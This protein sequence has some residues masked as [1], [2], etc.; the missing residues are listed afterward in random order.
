MKPIV[1]LFLVVAALQAAAPKTNLIILDET[2]VK[3]L[4]IALTEAEETVFEK[5]IFA[6]GRTGVFFWELRL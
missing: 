1:T 4:G 6:L 3:N 2:R 5:T